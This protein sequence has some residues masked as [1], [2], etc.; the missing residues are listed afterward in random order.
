MN[1]RQRKICLNSF[2]KKYIILRSG[3]LH[4]RKKV[5]LLR[6]GKNEVKNSI[7]DAKNVTENHKKTAIFRENR[8][9][10]ENYFFV[11][12]KQKR[13]EKHEKTSFK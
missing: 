12:I 6:K 2:L 9:R 8:K 3:V 1:C 13:K 11:Y 4:S 7:F 10:K 5:N